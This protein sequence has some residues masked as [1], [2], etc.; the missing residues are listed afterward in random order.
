MHRDP[1]FPGKKLPA[2]RIIESC[3]SAGLRANSS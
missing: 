2:S 1:E 3:T